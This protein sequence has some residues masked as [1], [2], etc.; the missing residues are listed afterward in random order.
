ME[1]N[2]DQIQTVYFQGLLRSCVEDKTAK[3]KPDSRRGV[4]RCWSSEGES[5]M[6][7]RSCRAMWAGVEV[8][9]RGKSGSR[10][11]VSREG[12]GQ[13]LQCPGKEGQGQGL[14]CP[15]GGAWPFKSLQRFSN[16]KIL[17]HYF[18]NHPAV[19]RMSIKRESMGANEQAVFF[20]NI[21]CV[22]SLLL[23]ALCLCLCLYLCLFVSLS[24]SLS[25]SLSVKYIV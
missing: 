19:R 12:Q 3:K 25:S 2:Y 15:E 8:N 17:C 24:V 23:L 14:R 9:V 18:K 11:A 4:S 13:G 16:R 20:R 10:S 5:F 21:Q 7:T 22:P 6:L 1:N